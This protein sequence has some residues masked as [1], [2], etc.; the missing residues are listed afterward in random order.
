MIIR[1]PYIYN[2]EGYDTMAKDP[3]EHYGTQITESILGSF[4][5]LMFA[6]KLRSTFS[7]IYKESEKDPEL[8][9]AL[10]DYAKQSKRLGAIMKNVCDRNPNFPE[11]KRNRKRFRR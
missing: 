10:I 3:I 11:C 1:Y 8:K 6:P 2:K 5:G 4:L 7:K 9:A